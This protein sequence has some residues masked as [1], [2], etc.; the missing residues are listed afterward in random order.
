VKIAEGRDPQTYAII[1]AAMEIHRQLGHGF[2]E[3]VYQDAAVI[4]FPLRKIPFEKEVSLPI[5]YKDIL[6]P[7]HYR[8]DF[9]C[10]SE[11][12][13]EF[14]ALSHLSSVE[15]AQLLN[16]LKAT[17]LKR[18]LLINFGASSLQYKRMVWGYENKDIKSA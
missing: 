9:I 1:G 12:I 5:R 18:G 6:L 2:L 7:S 11:I 15:E 13:V 8:A 10:F 3:A 17:G 16:Y 4:E 14:K